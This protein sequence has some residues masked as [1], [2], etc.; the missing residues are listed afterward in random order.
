MK[1]L[2]GSSAR[3][4]VNLM[5]RKG[6]IVRVYDPLF[7]YKEL[8]EKGYPAERTLKETIEQTDCL[9]ITVGH[10]QFKQLNLKRIK[11]LARKSVAIV[12]IGYVIDPVKAVRE[13][14]IYRGLGRGVPTK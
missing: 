2:Y 8:V 6:M 13:G 9:V 5:K 14:F 7:S 4:L 11:L 3:K 1:E 10:D 12:D